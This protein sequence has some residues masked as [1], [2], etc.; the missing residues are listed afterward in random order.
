L[1]PAAPPA[2]L[3]LKG[4]ATVGAPLPNGFCVGGTPKSEAAAAGEESILS[5]PNLKVDAAEGGSVFFEN[6]PK[7]DGVPAG[8]ACGELKAPLPP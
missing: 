5:P 4:A 6:E 7:T 2:A 8:A 3:K 1:D